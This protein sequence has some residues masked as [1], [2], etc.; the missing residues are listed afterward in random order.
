MFSSLRNTLKKIIQAPYSVYLLIIAVGIVSYGLHLPKLG[1]YWDDWPWVW[2]L[3]INGAQDMLKIDE[4]HRPLSGLVLY[5][6]GLFAG[7]NPVLWQ[8]YSL[9]LR[10]SGAGALAWALQKFWADQR[11]RI[12][13]VV[14]L[15]LVYP[16]FSQQFVSVNNSRHLFPLAIFFLS[17]GFMLKAIQEKEHSLLNTTTS[18]VL[19]LFAMLTSEYYYGLEF[20]RPVILWIYIYREQKRFKTSAST[21]LKAWAPYA[22]LLIF[23]FGWRYNVSTQLN[24]SITIFNEIG[25]NA[26]NGLFKLIEHALTDLYTATIGAW[27]SI[28]NFKNLSEYGNRI[29]LYYWII[30]VS[31][32]LGTLLYFI[33]LYQEEEEKKK[34]W[35]AEA[36]I[37][38]VAALLISPLPFWATGLDPKLGFPNDRLLLPTALGASLLLM[39]LIDLLKPR[40]VQIML[41]ALIIG[42]SAGSHNQNALVYRS[43]WT[44]TTGFFQQLSTRAPTLQANTTILSNQLPGRSTDN[45]LIAPLNWVYAPNFTD[46]NIPLQLLYVDLRFGRDETI[47]DED[48]FTSKAY[49]RYY[50]EGSLDNVV[51]IFY[52][53]PAC[54]QVI[55]PKNLLRKIP[56]PMDTAVPYSNPAL[57]FTD[58]NLTASLPAFFGDAQETP[59]W[60]YYF[61]KADLARQ[62]QNWAEIAQLGDTAFGA[63]KNPNHP[64]ERIPFI[65]GYAYTGQWKKA[66]EITLDVSKSSTAFCQIWVKIKTE[67]SPSAERETAI[68]NVRSH[69]SC[70]FE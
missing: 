41:L 46:G 31:V 55:D 50:F 11:D 18:L 61:E 7:E 25:D 16:G 4:H 24:Y 65:E 68:A 6:G 34:T 5:L 22:I 21:A 60:C 37:L 52:Q 53:P 13:W 38:G 54:L 14:L 69:L 19:S 26:R 27:G 17:L 44:S 30:V 40:S 36:F 43:A 1:F 42:L 12:V 3:H 58:A 59:T 48:L 47:I 15:F 20:I 45:S 63:G 8:S 23:V 28:F 67:T 2:S 33:L 35:R 70:G 29:Q 62:T 51:T 57:I 64:S 56:A 32:S 66:E 9:F 49:M 39:A 10:L